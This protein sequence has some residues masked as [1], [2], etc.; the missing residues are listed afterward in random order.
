MQALWKRIRSIRSSQT[1]AIK[2][3]NT[4]RLEQAEADLADLRRRAEIAT[5]ALQARKGRNGWRQA[6]EELIQGV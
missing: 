4:L 6:V 2:H 3:D 5:T 1:E